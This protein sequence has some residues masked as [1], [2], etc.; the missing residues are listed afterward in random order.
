MAG[1]ERLNL[2]LLTVTYLP[3]YLPYLSIDRDPSY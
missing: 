1:E 3:T 2:A